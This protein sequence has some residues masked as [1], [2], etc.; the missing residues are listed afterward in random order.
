LSSV[1]QGH[2]NLAHSAILLDVDGTLLDIA[3]TPDAVKV[4]ASLIETLAKVRDAT[5]GAVA[6]I[7]GRPL[8]ELDRIFVPLSLAVIGGHG[9]E[10]RLEARGGRD[11]RQ[12]D[13]IEDNLRQRLVN[14]G[15]VTPG[16][17]VED[18]NYAIALHYR[19]APD[20][21]RVLYKEVADI[22]AHTTQQGLHVLQGKSVIEVKSSHFNKG[23]AVR[24]LMAHSPFKGRRPIFIGDDVTDEDV[25]PVLPEFGGIG[26]PVGRA[27]EGVAQAFASPGDVRAW[28]A[29]LV[30]RKRA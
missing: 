17:L 20:V 15:K 4:P 13:P 24:D 3:S 9:A 22:C 19:L 6:L 27:M 28:L 1:L 12:A 21:E 14:I 11:E 26:L 5:G 8:A 18:K 2:V 23:T 10:V 30:E 29:N 16:V 25:F 7:S